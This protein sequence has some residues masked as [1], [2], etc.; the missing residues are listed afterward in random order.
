M[1]IKRNERDWAGQLISWIKI[2]IDKKAT[3]FQ[4]VTN[5]T[6]V[7]TNSGK[8]K[9]P[10]ILLFIDKT[11]GVVFN[12]WEL[13]FPDTAVD[14][15]EM[16]K[17]ALEKAENLKADS[18]VTWNGAETIIWKINTDYYDIHTLTKLKVY[19]KISTI[20]TREDLADSTKYLQNEPFLRQRAEEVLHHLD[21]LYTKGELKPAVDISGDIIESVQKASNIVIPQFYNAIIQEKGSNVAFR[22]EFARWRIYES[23]T[24]KIL[25]S[26]SRKK[27]KIEEEYIL[28]K[29]T[30]YNLIGKILFYL[31]LSENLKGE[32]PPIKIDV[33][34]D[35]KLLLKNYFE[36]A[37]AIDYQA[38]FQPYFTDDIPYS[39]VANGALLQLLKLLTSF[40]FKILPTEVIGHILEN[41]VPNDEKQKFGQYFTPDILAMLVAFPIVQ[42]KKDFLFDP[43]SGTGTFLNAFYKILS[44]LG[45]KSHIQLLNQIWGN[46]ISHFPAIL[47]VINLYKQDVSETENFPRVI[48]DD[49]FN[50]E[51]EKLIKFP[52]P[53]NHKEYIEVPIPLFDGIASNFPFIQQEDIPKEQKVLLDNERS[54]YFVYCVHNAIRFLKPN[55]YLSAITSNAWLG[56]EY[57]LL[58]KQILLDN[59]HIKYI[60]KSTAEHWFKDSQ[61]STIYFVLQKVINKEPTKFVTINFKLGSYFNQQTVMEKLSEMESFYADIDNCEADYNKNW[62]R[63]T[64][65]GNLYRRKDKTLSVTIVSKQALLNSLNTKDNWNQFFI[66]NDV[67]S[68]FEGCLTPYFPNIID[69]FRGERTGWNNMFVIKNKNLKHIG[70]DEKYL[71]P[72]IKSPSEIEKIDF[73]DNYKNKLFVCN[74]PFELL[75]E[76]TKEWIDKFKNVSNKNGSKTIQESCGNHRPYWY[77]LQP[78]KARIVT[79]INVNERFFFAFSTNPFTMDQRLIAIDVK[80]PYDTELIAALLNSAVTFLILELR[81]T[82]RNL[83][84]LD[85]NANYLKEIRL[86]NPDLL[87]DKQ[88]RSIIKAFQPL[89]DRKVESI[90]KEILHSDRKYFDTV[91]LQS[92]G[93]NEKLLENIYQTL[94]EV[95]RNRISMKEK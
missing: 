89:K 24:F 77:S 71:L 90:D 30:F 82:A 33:H 73:K 78:K 95:V 44:Y 17:N 42:T 85:L 10:D 53:N 38:V 60:V 87:K 48:R 40:D 11:S 88:K 66:P 74:T 75:D 45:E 93:L 36:K 4:D 15:V 49:F 92:F 51:V 27:E 39:Q 14:D 28:A 69:V 65:T 34:T 16:L 64:P 5:D 20:N 52:N 29:F 43:T 19:P 12:G 56:K 37:R 2:L 23:S 25:T 18:F 7:R 81:G 91:I 86:L 13:K 84:A 59:F 8:T 83:G 58:F 94:I 50:L 76:K 21:V 80:A 79:S 46:D 3:V 70:I 68:A 1:A 6:S 67:L 35:A 62:E 63:I 54:D 32:L 47:S 61:V 57:G 9:F 26:S 31:T 22:K 72:Y 41:L 55:G